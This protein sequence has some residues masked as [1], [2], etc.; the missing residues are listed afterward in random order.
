M[1][2]LWWD[3]SKVGLGPSRVRQK[4]DRSDSSRTR[5]GPG[6]TKLS[7][8]R[9]SADPPYPPPHIPPIYLTVLACSSSPPLLFLCLLTRWLVTW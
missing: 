7:P 9:A 6:L 8:H 5:V 1:G 4:S 2:G 3:W